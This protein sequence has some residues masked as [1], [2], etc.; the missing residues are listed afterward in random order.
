M[1]KI[2]K[3]LIISLLLLLGLACIGVLYIFFVPG[4]SLFNITY[5][6]YNEDHFSQAID[7]SSINTIEMNSNN[8]KIK[9]ISTSEDSISVK[10]H[11]ATSGFVFTENKNLTLTHS[12]ASGKLT[13]DI[14][15]P[16]GVALNNNSYIEL[17]IPEDTTYNM[18]LNNQHAETNINHESLTI[19][20]LNYSTRNGN[21][22][23]NN[24]TILGTMDLN[25]SNA[26]FTILPGVTTNGNKVILKLDSGKFN[27]GSSVFGELNIVENIKGNIIAQE[28]TS[29]TGNIKQTGGR[30]TITTLDTINYTSSD[31]II[32]INELTGLGNILLTNS[33]SVN[34]G[35]LNINSTIET[36]NGNITIDRAECEI[37]L[38][39]STN[40][41]INVKSATKKINAVTVYGNIDITFDENAES[42]AA[43]TANKFI[44]ATT[45]NG[46]ITVINAEHIEL[47]ITRNGRAYVDM[48]KLYGS[49]YI[50][51]KIGEVSAVINKDCSYELITNTNSGNISVDLLHLTSGL[52]SGPVNCTASA[53]KLNITTT[54][55][56]IIVKDNH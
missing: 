22:N 28:L 42:Y 9:V 46:K 33:G 48:K 37:T 54:A 27:A 1:K 34:I 44:H 8:Y 40:G 6:S 45:E 3:Y 51:G 36:T 53:N 2:G 11:C 29:L 41:N 7:A 20:K 10:V 38:L 25:L 56:N 35:T 17:R 49:N 50:L 31:T 26:V 18:E 14:I 13:F 16:Y 32:T 15:E 52:T 19:N 4:A 24:G 55:G 30:I 39:K 12:V 43:N 21:F 5:I 23:L 47:S